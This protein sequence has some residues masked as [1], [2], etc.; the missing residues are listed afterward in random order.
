MPEARTGG[1]LIVDCLRAQG[2]DRVFCVPGESYLPV[3][4]ALADGGVDVVVARQEG[5]AAMMAE[6]D[7]KITGRPGV[8]LVTRGPGATNAAAGVHVAKQDSTPMVLLVGQI[9]RRMRGREAFQEVDYR[10]TFGDLAKWVDQIDHA[11]R[12]PEVMSHAWH[13]ALSGRT[14]PVVLALPEDMLTE[15]AEVEAGP[16]VEVAEPAPTPEAVARFGTMLRAAERP[17]MVLGGARWTAEAVADVMAF[18]EA[19]DL[20]TGVSFRRQSLFDAA[21]PAYA[22]DVGL[23]INPKLKARIAGADLVILLGARFSENPS[24]DFTLLAMPRPAQRLVHVHPGA[25]ELGRLY[26]PDLPVCATP[27]AFLRAARALTPPPRATARTAAAHAEYR[28]WSEPM[29]RDLPGVDMAAVMAHL[30]AA[31]PADAIL[32]NGAGNY[33]IWLHRFHRFRGWGTQLAPTSGS[34]GYGLPA[35]VAAKLRYPERPVICFAGDGCF[36]MTMQEFGTACQS[37]AA[38]VVLVCDNGGYGTI[39]MHQERRYPGRVSATALD[40][41]DFAALAR[42][43]G[44]HAETVTQS[45]DFGPAFDRALAAGRPALLH[46]RCAM[47]AITPAATIASLRAGG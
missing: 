44:A 9:G 15:T 29:R 11:D 19:W 43:Y 22:G 4:D 28:T 24:Q 17:V 33:A 21:H 30:R 16:R 39:R 25:E 7:G 10:Q 14:G 31:L 20:P 13:V 12:I 23:G 1:R 38:V 42:A 45:E 27:G 32:T 41:P 40:N 5:G 8:C 6:A 34:M 26:A 46:L 36:Q 2:V 37:G 18:A 3:L 35:A 47:E